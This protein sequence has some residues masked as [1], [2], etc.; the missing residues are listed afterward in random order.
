[1]TLDRGV[2]ASIDRR[3][4]AEFEHGAGLQLVKV[5]LSDAVWSTWRRY[6]TAVGVTMG[7]GI[8]HL[9]VHE[10]GS[11]I[12]TVDQP[13]PVLAQDLEHRFAD[14]AAELDA[15]DRRLNEREQSIRAS[16][17]SLRVRAA[18]HE[19]SA[20]M[21]VGRNDPCPCGSGLKYKRCH[22]NR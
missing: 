16:E 4:F 20:P 17:Q 14:R 2:L 19:P 11:V 22:A 12:R 3:V 9:V 7:G 5:P 15:R 21:R 8:A 13:G 18:I 10:L 1:M 6:C